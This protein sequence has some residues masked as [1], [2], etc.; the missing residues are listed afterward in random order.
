LVAEKRL[1]KKTTSRNIL[2]ATP[3]CVMGAGGVGIFS[4]A[5]IVAYSYILYASP[6]NNIA[7]AK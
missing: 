1:S 3:L 7:A 6:M 4:G 2:T 5:G